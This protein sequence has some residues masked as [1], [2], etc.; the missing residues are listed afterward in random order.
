MAFVR[1][2]L[3]EIRDRLAADLLARLPQGDSQPAWS[4]PGVLA[5]VWALVFHDLFGYAGFIS[6]QIIVDTAE[7]DYLERQAGVWGLTR[8]GEAVA[9]G[10]AALSGTTGT[11][12]PAGTILQ[13]GEG[14]RFTTDA[15]AT[16]AAGTAEPGITAEDPGGAGNLAADAVLALVSPIAG[17]SAAAVGAGGLSGGADVES[18]DSL[19]T[20]LLQRIQE[21]PHGGA[22]H[23]YLGWA[24]DREAHGRAVTRAWVYPQEL[25][26]GTVTVRFMMDDTYGDGIPLAG[27]VTAVQ[28][29]IDQERPVTAAVTVLAPLA[30]PLDFEISIAPS[31]DAVKA[32]VAAELADLIAREAAPGGTL[33]LSHIREAISLA[34]GEY[35]HGLIAPAAAVV[36]ATGEIST[37]GEITWS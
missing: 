28:A 26:I 16:I 9:S 7:S 35:D 21:P 5:R 23:D 27:D 24:L 32:A 2:T 33:L 34:A 14:R 12:I 18:D 29:T 6:R 1:P 17:V 20:R 8:A 22:G 19:R 3:R 25:G 10:T 13:D 11:V 37:M 30:V 15:E 36:R 31:T 4:V